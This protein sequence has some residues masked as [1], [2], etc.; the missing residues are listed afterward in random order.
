MFLPVEHVVIFYHDFGRQ[1]EA[2]GFTED[3]VLANF[4][5]RAGLAFADQ[6]LGFFFRGH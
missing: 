1:S 4:P 2:A 5:I 3:E 6:E